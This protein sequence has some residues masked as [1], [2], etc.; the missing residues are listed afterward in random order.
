MRNKTILNRAW[1][2]L[3]AVL[4]LLPIISCTFITASAVD[5]TKKGSVTITLADP[6]TG[7]GIEGAVIELYQVAEAKSVD[8]MLSFSLTSGFSGSGVSLKDLEDADLAQ[9][10]ADYAA[11]KPTLQK[12]TE[13]S[14]K[15]GTLRFTG[16]D[17][18]IYLA[19]QKESAGG[20]YPMSPF[21][22]SL[23]QTA[24]NGTDWVFDVSASPK[25]ELLPK[26]PAKL[27]VKK[28][29]IDNDSKNRPISVTVNLLNGTEVVDTVTLNAANKWTHTWEDL[30]GTVEWTVQETNVPDTYK[31]SYST[32]GTVV[33]ITNATSLLQTGQLNWPVPVLAIAGL[34]LFAF[35]WALTF[36]SRKN[37]ENET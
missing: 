35:G 31:V 22:V 23:P 3:L 18:G 7:A 5:L 2:T 11:N 17:T 13:T 36:F 14:G 20:C 1:V 28:E 12:R 32:N 34:L 6:E 30:D 15:D 10:L 37:G 25:M 26:E 16:L 8:H 9:K 29:W 27:T 4:L 24:D 19:V 33:T 21:L